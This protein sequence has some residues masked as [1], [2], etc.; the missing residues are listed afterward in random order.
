MNVQGGSRIFRTC[1]GILATVGFLAAAL[2][3]AVAGLTGLVTLDG[4]A[5][6]SLGS[7][8]GASPLFFFNTGLGGVVLLGGASSNSPGT[9]LSATLFDATI[10]LS[11]NSAAPHILHFV[12]EDNG[13]TSPT[14]LVNATSQSLASSTTGGASMDAFESIVAGTSIVTSGLPFAVVPGSPYSSS[15]LTASPIAIPVG[16]FDMSQDFTI[17]LLA[18][19][20]MNFSNSLGTTPYV[21][22]GPVPEP[23]TLTYGA[24]LLS[25]GA[26]RLLRRKRIR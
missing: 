12:F 1:A 13:Y 23:G 10:Q 15:T 11:N 3:Q 18:G 5:P 2:P 25:I 14:G 7:A 17:T 21:N 16:T 19:E 4:G 26:S 9:V 8:S 20:N 22:L 6:V 24:A